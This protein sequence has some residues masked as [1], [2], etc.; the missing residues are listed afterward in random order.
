M[1]GFGQVTPTAVPAI[2]QGLPGMVGLPGGTFQMGAS[3]A[4]PVHPVTVS[5]F[6]MSETLVTNKQYRKFLAAQ[7]GLP[8]FALQATYLNGTSSIVA[9]EN[10]F[11]ALADHVARLD[12]G[13][14][15]GVHIL[16]QE[17]L[18]ALPSPKGFDADDQ[19]VV[20]VTWDEA[21]RY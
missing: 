19:P 13:S 7:E 18:V 3:F 9:R 14:I 2:L 21:L 17:K 8:Q 1:M 5:A 4:S 20:C 12:S 11:R 16:R 10:D 6:A 15:S